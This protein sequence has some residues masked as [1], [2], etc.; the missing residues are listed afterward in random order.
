MRYWLVEG[1]GERKTKN[2]YR[3][4]LVDVANPE[5][6]RTL[7]V[8]GGWWKLIEQRMLCSH[9]G[10]KRR[11][12]VHLAKFTFFAISLNN[13]CNLRLHFNGKLRR[14]RVATVAT[15]I[16]ERQYATANGNF[17]FSQ[18][19]NV[20]VVCGDFYRNQFSKL[21]LGIEHFTLFILFV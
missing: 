7:Y 11:L 19:N 2:Y 13:R 10:V 16:T 21:H 1:A 9:T 4:G 15:E 12:S 17:V 8:W 14:R 20:P 5:A 18:R 3:L 6:N